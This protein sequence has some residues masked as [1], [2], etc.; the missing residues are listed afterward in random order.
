MDTDRD[1]DPVLKAA[2]V[3]WINKLQGAKQHKRKVF[4]EDA[5]ECMSFYAGPRSWNELMGGAE[6]LAQMEDLPD[7][8][9]KMRV[10]KAFEMVGLFGPALYYNNPT[11]TVTP[12]QPLDID[13]SVF[14]D[15]YTAQ[16][17][18]VQ[19]QQR[20]MVDD[21]RAQ[22]LER[23]LNWLPTETHLD[24]ES[25]QAIEEALIKGRG[26]IWTELVTPPGT[27]FRVVA[28]TFDSADNL[29]V[30]PDAPSFEKATWIA[31][32]CC[33]PVWQVERDYGLAPGTLRGNL[34]S[35]AIQ[36]EVEHRDDGDYDRKRGHTNDLL[37]YWKIWS[38]MGIG[39]RLS[40]IDRRFRGPLEM[41]GDYVYLVVA[42]GVPFPLN[43]SP[44]VQKQAGFESDPQAILARV[45]W[46]TPFWADGGWPVA[47]LDF[48]RV[49]GC[50]WPTSHLK[51]GLGELKFLNW[52]YS[53]LAGKMRN[54]TRD[55][56]AVLKSAGDE[57]N[58]SILNGRDLTL[59]EIDENHK[60]IG[61]VVSFLQHPQMNADIWKVIAS[62][63]ENFDKRVGLNELMY[64][65]IGA[66]Q[67]RS[68]HEVDVR[69]QNSNVRPDDM[70]KQAEAWMSEVAAREAMCARYH[71]QA[72]DIAPVLG[73]L[74]G[75]VWGQFVA[76]R[77]L[78]DVTRQLDY[79]IESGSARKPNRETAVQNTQDSMQSLMPVFQQYAMAT[80]DVGPLN[81]LI[82]DW[83]R[84]RDLDPSRY[85]LAPPP[86]MPT[87]PPEPAPDPGV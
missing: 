19:E 70:A 82:G 46:P 50:P 67:A 63:E 48:H 32:R 44:E 16:A 56:V 76:S 61:E 62:V 24:R 7:P 14:G 34:E 85:Q 36:A 72:G 33:H 31:R 84:A 1:A 30:D 39:G 22:V 79:R 3:H 10:N 21:L 58:A 43:L 42:E 86:P 80:G 59:L 13:P 53:F 83:A 77:D 29:Q 2:C 23:Y 37:T 41:F 75:Q 40:G 78:N 26:C 27:D 5:D 68:A 49:P 69:N 60:T 28:S 73:A 55:F 51:A 66:T 54:T 9:F 57:L 4:Q 12:R 81:A 6:G 52:S 17:I 8:M 74:A 38:K 15:P 64:G 47:V 35:Q 65:G 25:R 11:R 45:A 71:L 87:A 18:A 20:L